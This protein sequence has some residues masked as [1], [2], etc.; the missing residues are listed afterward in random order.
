M[1]IRLIEDVQN[2]ILRISEYRV[3]SLG[4]S[5]N[6]EMTARKQ[7]SYSLWKNTSFFS[8]KTHSMAIF[9]NSYL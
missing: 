1:S 9:N 6:G 4:F 7:Q 8:G 3:G 2:Y 5:E